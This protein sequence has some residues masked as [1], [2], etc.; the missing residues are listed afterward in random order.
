MIPLADGAATTY[1]DWQGD[2]MD[3]VTRTVQAG[4]LRFN[5]WL[6]VQ[7]WTILHKKYYS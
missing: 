2:G 3:A 7:K 5:I 1:D 6:S 4:G